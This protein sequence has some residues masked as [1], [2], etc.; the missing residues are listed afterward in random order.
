MSDASEHDS[1]D[2]DDDD[3]DGASEDASGGETEE[4]TND[5]NT[6]ATFHAGNIHHTFAVLLIVELN[7]KSH[8]KFKLAVE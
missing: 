2:I 7:I 3:D 5:K 1:D 8:W 4:L 6:S